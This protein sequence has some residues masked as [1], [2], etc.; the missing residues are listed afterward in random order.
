M[1]FGPYI[2]HCQE[3]NNHHAIDRSH[4][5]PSLQHFL[6]TL[7][8]TWSTFQLITH[9]S[10]VSSPSVGEDGVGVAVDGETFKKYALAAILL[11][12]ANVVIGLVLIVLA[13]LGC[14]RRGA[15]SRKSSV[16][17]VAP[18]YTPVKLEE[19]GYSGHY[20]QGYKRQ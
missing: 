16:R 14:M 4:I 19:E 12:A 2:S 13:V 18:Q 3:A 5:L 15:A 8:W 17:V 1:Y 7:C 20:Q 10:R 9:S 6:L 11:L